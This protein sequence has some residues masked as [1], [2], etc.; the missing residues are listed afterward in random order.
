VTRI[1]LL[2]WA[3]ALGGLLTTAAVI[4]ERPLA[5]YAVSFQPQEPPMSR[6][7]GINP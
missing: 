2:I 3:F 5:Q 4:A 7:A 6:L 1:L